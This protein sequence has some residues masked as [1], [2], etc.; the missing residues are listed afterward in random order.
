MVAVRINPQH[1]DHFFFLLVKF[2]GILHFSRV[3]VLGQ[4]CQVLVGNWKGTKASGFQLIELVKGFRG[5]FYE[6]KIPDRRQ[7]GHIKKAGDLSCLLF[8]LVGAS[9]LNQVWNL[10]I[11]SLQSSS[12]N[13]DYYQPILIRVESHYTVRSAA[14]THPIN[15]QSVGNTQ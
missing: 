8:V 15:T 1:L 13:R 5:Y 12:Q 10:L 3:S 11:L 7:S 9:P 6:S 14:P 2:F 4:R